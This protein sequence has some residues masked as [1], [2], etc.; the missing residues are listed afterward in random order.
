MS[1][2]DVGHSRGDISVGVGLKHNLSDPVSHPCGVN[3]V[4]IGVNFEVVVRL[5]ILIVVEWGAWVSWK[6]NSTIEDIISAIM[7]WVS[8]YY[9]S[10]LLQFTSLEHFQFFEEEREVVAINQSSE[11]IPF[12]RIA[13]SIDGILK[14]WVPSSGVVKE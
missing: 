14:D 11:F 3:H 10:I 8:S 9:R 5:I 2:V 7:V 1:C 12:S 4:T 13:G 6:T